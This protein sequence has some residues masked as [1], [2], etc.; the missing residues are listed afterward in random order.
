MTKENKESI[1]KLSRDFRLKAAELYFKIAKEEFDF[2][3]E[4][5][6]QLLQDLPQDRDGLLSTQNRASNDNTVETSDN[7]DAMEGVFTQRPLLPRADGKVNEKSSKM[8][9]EY[10][11]IALKRAVLESDKEIHFLLEHSVEETP[12]GIQ[13]AR[14]LNPVLRKDF[15]LQA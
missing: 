1:K 12:F 10:I 11:E 9:A 13:E 15:V 5:L 2:Q 14:D 6:D 8:Y 3:K 7:E 4:R